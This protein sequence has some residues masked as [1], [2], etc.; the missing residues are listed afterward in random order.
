MENSYKR[1][2]RSYY[3]RQVAE[4]GKGKGVCN[5]KEECRK[6]ASEEKPFCY[7]PGRPFIG[8]DYGKRD[9]KK[10]VFIGINPVNRDKERDY[11]IDLQRFVSEPGFEKEGYWRQVVEYVRR[12]N[13]LKR[14]VPPREVL[15]GVAIT[16]GVRCMTKFHPV[17]NRARLPTDVMW[18]KCSH[19]LIKELEIL[20]PRLIVTLGVGKPGPWWNLDSKEM[21]VFLNTG[22]DAGYYLYA[23]PNSRVGRIKALGLFHPSRPF[24]HRK[25]MN[26]IKRNARALFE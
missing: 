21:K 14:P 7:L 12:I 6:S 8:K 22:Q 16:N 1:K 19:H 25:N 20:R 13:H 17:N 5:F 2:V 9:K 24:N 10:I 15:N 11:A 4:E 18:R 3:S 26:R 23:Y